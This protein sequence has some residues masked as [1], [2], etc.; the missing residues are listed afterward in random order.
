[1]AGVW[2]GSQPVASGSISFVLGDA[3]LDGF[4]DQHGGLG[5][6]EVRGV[7]DLGLVVQP[8]TGSLCGAI[9]VPEAE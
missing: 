8:G 3:A 4:C 9:E 7:E 2:V 5:R 1:L 6:R